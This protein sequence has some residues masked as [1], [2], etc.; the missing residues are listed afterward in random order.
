MRDD[1]QGMR[2]KVTELEIKLDRVGAG[3]CMSARIS[4]LD[5]LTWITSGLSLLPF[6]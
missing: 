6:W 2:D 3:D 5:F 4:H 1:L